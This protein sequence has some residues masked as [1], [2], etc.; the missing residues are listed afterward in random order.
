MYHYFVSLQLL[1]FSDTN[2]ALVTTVAALLVTVYYAC[3][4]HFDACIMYRQHCS[5]C[6]LVY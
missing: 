4:V 1:I 3:T 5:A 6:F 2:S